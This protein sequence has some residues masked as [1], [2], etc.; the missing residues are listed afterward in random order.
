MKRWILAFLIIGCT[1]LPVE[2]VFEA[3]KTVEAKKASSSDQSLIAG[4]LN[5]RDLTNRTF[6]FMVPLT[7]SKVLSLTLLSG[8]KVQSND[9]IFISMLKGIG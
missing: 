3:F 6:V 1:C 5:A 2:A 7:K 8:G 9:T 4:Q